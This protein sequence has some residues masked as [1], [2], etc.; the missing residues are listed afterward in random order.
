M[1]ISLEAKIIAVLVALLFGALLFGVGYQYGG[2]AR[3][4]KDDL[5]A[6]K[7]Q[8]AN[9]KIINDARNANDA[10]NQELEKQH[11]NSVNAL[12]TIMSINPPVVRLPKSSCTVRSKP[13][14]G[15]IQTEQAS[16]VLPTEAERILAADRQRT[17]GIE[18]EAEQELGDCRVPKAWA[19]A[20]S[21]VK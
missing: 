5:K 11:E 15:S 4:I 20:Q 17:W 7:L 19:A 3:G 6:A 13:S 10:L 1:T 8:L 12:N 14:G 16:G 18:S 21:Q 2:K 9:D